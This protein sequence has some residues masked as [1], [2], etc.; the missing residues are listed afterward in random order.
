[1]HKLLE[2]FGYGRQGG[3]SPN[4][5]NKRNLWLAGLAVIGVLML[6]YAGFGA[7]PAKEP[8]PNTGVAAGQAGE[9]EKNIMSAEEAILSK[10]LCAM[11]RQIAGAGQV[12]VSVR[13]SETTR[14]EYAVNT[15]TGK[16]TTQERDQSGG[17][18]L[19]TED[20]DSNQLVMHRSG[21]EEQPVMEREVAPRVAGILVVAE[22]AGDPRVKAMLFQAT[23]VAM[24][25]EPQKILVLPKER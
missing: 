16:K 12:E 14:S 23:M 3:K 17:T 22:G 21:Q 11:L 19:T 7:P 24:G 10:N 5:A 9:P 1:M 15:T 4:A 2:F 25:V 8:P 20:N 18:R 6:V 13:L